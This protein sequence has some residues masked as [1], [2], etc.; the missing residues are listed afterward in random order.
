MKNFFEYDELARIA[1]TRKAMSLRRTLVERWQGLDRAE[2]SS[3]SDRIAVAA[4]LLDG[5]RRVADFGCGSMALERHLVPD[6]LY[7]PVDVVR[8]DERTIIVDLN[9]D[10][11]PEITADACVGLGLLEYLFDVPSF[12]LAARQRYATL[13]T[14]YNPVEVDSWEVEA[15]RAHAWVNDYSRA[16]LEAEFAQAEWTIKQTVAAG[17]SQLVWKLG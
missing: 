16:Q 9:V 1:M 8:R 2:S 17:E 7:L 10:P 14:S 3:W 12:L 6:S 11:F 15:R 13:V 5:V 4:A